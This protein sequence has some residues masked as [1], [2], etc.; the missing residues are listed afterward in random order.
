MKPFEWCFC[1]GSSV[2]GSNT[3]RGHRITLEIPIE[4]LEDECNMNMSSFK[5]IRRS[6]DEMALRI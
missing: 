6:I 3:E 1:G 4:V 5:E 2:G